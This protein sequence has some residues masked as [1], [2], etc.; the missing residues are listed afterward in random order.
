MEM[1]IQKNCCI[2]S[3]EGNLYAHKRKKGKLIWKTVL[4]NPSPVPSGVGGINTFGCA[5]PE[6]NTLYYPSII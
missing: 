2:G 3:K 6:T 1:E 4:T 5:N